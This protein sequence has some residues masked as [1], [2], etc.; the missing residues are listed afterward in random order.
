MVHE[1][2]SMKGERNLRDGDRIRSQTLLSLDF[3]KKES[4]GREAFERMTGHF[5]EK[6]DIEPGGYKHLV[7]WERR[8]YGHLSECCPLQDNRHRLKADYQKKDGEEFVQKLQKK[9]TARR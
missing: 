8:R 9:V 2:Y 3:Y 5:L 1:V 6:F 7:C 4:E